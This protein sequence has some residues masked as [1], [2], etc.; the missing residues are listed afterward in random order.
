MIVKIKQFGEVVLPLGAHLK[1]VMGNLTEGV[2]WDILQRQMSTDFQRAVSKALKDLPAEEQAA[3]DII[4]FADEWKPVVKKVTLPPKI[5]K[6]AEVIPT[7]SE[8]QRKEFFGL[9]KERMGKRK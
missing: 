3:F 6:I 8:E 9:V 4:A 1:E 7:L 5:R 2:V